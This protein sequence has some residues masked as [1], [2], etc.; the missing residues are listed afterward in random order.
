MAEIDCRFFNGYK[1]CGKG[2]VCERGRCSSFASVGPRVLLVHLEAL[3]AVVR[4]TSL[5]AAIRREFAGCQITWVTKTPA[6]LENLGVE[7]V[8]SLSTE[9]LLK[10]EVLSFDV[11]LVID[12]SLAA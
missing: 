3:G 11:A 8:L 5:L 7:R 4:S 1:P 2:T 9:D 6:L 12:K 10:L